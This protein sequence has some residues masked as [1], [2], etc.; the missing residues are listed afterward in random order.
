MS[1]ITD[2]A[3]IRDAEN[4]LMKKGLLEEIRMLTEAIADDGGRKSDYKGHMEES[5]WE[6]NYTLY[7]GNNRPRFNGYKD[8]I[9]LEYEYREQMNVR[10]HLLM[11]EAAYRQNVIDAGVF[12]IPS[13]RDASVK[14][15]KRELKDELFTYHFPIYSPVYLIEHE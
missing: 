8:R 6:T 12:I 14:R 10:S 2:E 3:S 4:S 13:G 5:G 1:S 9:G 15:T 7:I 11:M